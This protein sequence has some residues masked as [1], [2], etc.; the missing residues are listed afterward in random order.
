MIQNRFD[1]AIL[2]DGPVGQLLAINLARICQNP[3]LI[4]LLKDP[5]NNP[6][7]FNQ[8]MAKDPR[9]LALNYGSLTLLESLK[10]KLRAVRDIKHIHVSQKDHFGR[11]IINSYDFQLPKLGV[12]VSYNELI[13]SLR[14]RVNQIGITCLQGSNDH[15]HIQQSAQSLQIRFGNSEIR[16]RIGIRCN[17]I[18]ASSDEITKSEHQYALISTVRSSLPMDSWAWECF[19][20]SGSLALLPCPG[21]QD[22]YSLVLCGPLEKINSLNKLDERR[23]SN[24]LSQIAGY[25]LGNLFCSEKRYVV[26]LRQ[27]ICTKLV[28]G[29]LISVGNSAQILHPVA[30][31]GLNLGFRDVSCLSESLR[32][33]FR[34][35]DDDPKMFLKIF[36]N[37]R[38]ADRCISIGVT[39]LLSSLFATKFT[40][41]QSACS[42]GLIA[43]DL[44]NP[45]RKLFV[46]H[47]LFGFR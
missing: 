46:K 3:N 6:E 14:E 30:G 2:G 5:K 21:S 13:S 47:F 29:R 36:L 33:W 23:L 20:E 37:S 25:H 9:V 32:V 43:L 41:I 40:I 31:Q 44:I 35:V 26:P 24:I 8:S 22:S 17:G 12:V 42:S 19:T 45:L 27:G 15:Y 38:N 11:C 10:V 1:V 39:N 28:E 7:S 34:N 4:V 18:I 16:A